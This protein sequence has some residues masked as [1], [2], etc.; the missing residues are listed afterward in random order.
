VLK[1]PILL[2]FILLGHFISHGVS[3]SLKAFF[4]SINGHVCFLHDIR[5]TCFLR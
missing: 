3:F 5:A 4:E 1:C 2:K